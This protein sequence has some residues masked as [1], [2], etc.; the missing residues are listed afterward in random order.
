[1]YLVSYMTVKNKGTDDQINTDFYRSFE[2]RYEAKTFYDRL[3]QIKEV[4]TANISLVLESTDYDIDVASAHLCHTEET[5]E[6]NPND[7]FESHCT[8]CK[9]LVMTEENGVITQ[10]KEYFLN[11]CFGHNGEILHCEDCR[12]DL[13][14]GHEE[15]E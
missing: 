3:L 8:F 9:E 10:H 6:Y 2:E 13:I 14:Q 4:D 11:S 12:V 7:Y 1:M 15:G 5:C